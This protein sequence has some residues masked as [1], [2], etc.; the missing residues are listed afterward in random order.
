MVGKEWWVSRNWGIGVAGQLVGAS[1]KD[2][3]A[4]VRPTWSVGSFAIAF[5][6]TFN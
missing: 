1:V 2:S 6:A 5:T 3:G 4:A